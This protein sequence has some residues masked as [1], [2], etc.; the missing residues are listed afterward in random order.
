MS[1]T[2]TAEELRAD[3]DR[4]RECIVAARNMLAPLRNPIMFRDTGTCAALTSLALAILDSE[5]GVLPAAA[6][7]LPAG[8][9]AGTKP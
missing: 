3:N 1:E 6:S 2:S 5:G 4:L 7:D 8:R 9:Q